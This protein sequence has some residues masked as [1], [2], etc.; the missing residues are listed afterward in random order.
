[1]GK[2][3]DGL[4]ESTRAVH[5]I[6]KENIAAIKDET[7]AFHEE[8]TEPHPG[9]ADLKEARGW[10]NK[11]KVVAKHIKEGA[12]EASEDEK[13]RRAKIQSHESYRAIL[14]EPRNY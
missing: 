6:N 5:E 13:A 9:A 10:K 4:K 1:M 14:D 3:T 7:K 12:K 8:V 2:I 11:A